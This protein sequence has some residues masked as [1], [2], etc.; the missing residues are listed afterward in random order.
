MSLNKHQ[1]FFELTPGKLVDLQINH[2]VKM[3]I[4]APLIGY[5]LGKYIILKHPEP[6]QINS[7]RDVFTEGNVVVVRYLLEGDQGQCFAFK[8]TIRNVTKIPEK[9]IFLTYPDKIENRELRTHQ[10]F[11]T[12]LPASIVSIAE[13]Q[14]TP[15]HE[16]K[17]I[18][19]DI[20]AKGCGF[21]FKTDN[22]KVKVNKRDV[23]VC[24]K[25]PGEETIT[26]PAKVCNSRYEAGK[27]NV[28]IQFNDADKQVKSI[29]EH[30]FIEAGLS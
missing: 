12:H 1:A 14:S 26:I 3:R 11:V 7:Y 18:I 4:K 27:V 10:R 2:P 17:G 22:A 9:F 20:S 25:M 8:S 13:E 15:S 16:L 6:K 23:L 29:L 19:A 28:G 21:I 30:L 24:I 5:E